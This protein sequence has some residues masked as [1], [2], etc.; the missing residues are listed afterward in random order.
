[1]PT[2]SPS[3]AITD[4][5]PRSGGLLVRRGPGLRLRA[6]GGT[7]PR[8][9]RASPR[10]ASSTRSPAAAARLKNSLPSVLESRF[11]CSVLVSP[12]ARDSVRRGQRPA[13]DV[14]G[15]VDVADRAEHGQPLAVDG[16]SPRRRPPTAR[17]PAWRGP[18]RAPPG[19]RRRSAR[20]STTMRHALAGDRAEAG[21]RL[22]VAHPRRRRSCSVLVTWLPAAAPARRCCSRSGHHPVLE[23]GRR[24][25]RLVVDL[26]DQRGPAGV[27]D[28][29]VARGLDRGGGHQD[30]EDRDHDGGRPVRSGPGRAAARR[31]PAARRRAGS[32]RPATA[33]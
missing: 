24:V 10:S 17:R 23:A 27:G 15:D 25:A 20:R 28:V 21:H 8:G 18:R 13:V 19:W 22:E 7:G 4:W 1:M 26:R 3:A 30:A 5:S 6:A 9:A 11:A 29:R 31:R 14:D 12:I 16:R 32:P 2:S 33:G